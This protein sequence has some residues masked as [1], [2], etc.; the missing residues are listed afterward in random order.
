VTP[1]YVEVSVEALQSLLPPSAL[2][3]V[4]IDEAHCVSHWG[5]DFRASYRKLNRLRRAYADVPFLALT[6][7]ATEEV[8]KDICKSLELV[9]P[10]VSKSSFDRPNLYIEVASKEGKLFLISDF[11]HFIM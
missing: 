8:V 1:E 7:T 6:A 10:A 11:L 5:Q 4:A 2:C 9:R 3:L